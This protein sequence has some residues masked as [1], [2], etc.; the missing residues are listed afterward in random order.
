MSSVGVSQF[1]DVE[2]LLLFEVWPIVC[3][4]SAAKPAVH[5]KKKL[6]NSLHVFRS[7]LQR[8]LQLE[9]SINSI[10]SKID[11]VVNKLDVLERNKLMRRDLLGKPL[12]NV[13][14]VGS[15]PPCI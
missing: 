7:L 13:S 12:D 15:P 6:A 1:S 8:V 4:I 5:H 10:G 2:H 14:K 11:A 3:K 9:Q